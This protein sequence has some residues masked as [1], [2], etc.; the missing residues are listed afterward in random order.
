MPHGHVSST[1]PVPQQRG[2]HLPRKIHPA[3]HSEPATGRR[4]PMARGTAAGAPATGS[5]LTGGSSFS[6]SWIFPV[7]PAVRRVPGE[8]DFHVVFRRRLVCGTS[9]TLGARPSGSW[10]HGRMFHQAA[11]LQKA[12]PPPVG[13]PRLPRPRTFKTQYSEGDGRA[14]RS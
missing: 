6:R 14:H 4:C 5:R 1:F 8:G 12:S 3:A 2:V 11:A 7:E 10:Q 13:L 9:P